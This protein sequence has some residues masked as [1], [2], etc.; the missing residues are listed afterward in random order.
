LPDNL[1]S[2]ESEF[3]IQL[4]SVVCVDE[5]GTQGDEVL[6]SC[7]VGRYAFDG[8]VHLLQGIAVFLTTT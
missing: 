1:L 6:A 2:T 5:S 3:S 4:A 7:H 8:H